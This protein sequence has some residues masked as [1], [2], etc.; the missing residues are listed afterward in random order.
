MYI[1][2]ACTCILLLSI[3]LCIAAC[4]K[5]AETKSVLCTDEKTTTIISTSILGTIQK[6][7]LQES[8]KMSDTFEP[9]L[10]NDYMKVTPE[11]LNFQR[12][13][14]DLTVYE[15]D[16]Y[17]VYEFNKDEILV[18]YI[19]D[20]IFGDPTYKKNTPVVDADDAISRVKN[21][22]EKT[23]EVDLS[24]YSVTNEI[25]D[26]FTTGDT[27]VYSIVFTK[28]VQGY[29]TNDRAYACITEYGY[30]CVFRAST[31][32][33]SQ[34]IDITETI[35]SE[36]LNA[37]LQKELEKPHQGEYEWKIDSETIKY[38]PDERKATFTYT[39]I[40]IT[41]NMSGTKGAVAKEYEF[42]LV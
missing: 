5:E 29:D 30:I 23:Y 12:S 21:F 13:S 3:C 1:K 18:S 38:Y 24:E 11:Q 27:T 14:G 7:E 25:D 4:T 41:T 15:D 10:N 26:E 2:R 9:N 22:F 8:E 34:G 6:S 35:D 36:S 17:N 37:L 40:E 42:D 16:D 39:I 31:L 32:G 33:V 20:K 28:K 19:D